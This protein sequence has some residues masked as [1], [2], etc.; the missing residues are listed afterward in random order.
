MTELNVSSAAGYALGL[1]TS[2]KALPFQ[3]WTFQDAGS[4]TPPPSS[5]KYTEL[6]FVVT[7]WFQ[8]SSIHCSPCSGHVPQRRS[9]LS[10]D[11]VG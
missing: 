1:V 3:Y 6:P 4:R 2:T 9:W 11:E 8:S 10:L 7:G 5:R